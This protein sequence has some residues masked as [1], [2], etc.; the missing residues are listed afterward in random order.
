LLTRQKT[1]EKRSEIGE[2]QTK[3]QTIKDFITQ[4]SQTAKDE[5]H[6]RAKKVG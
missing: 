6:K 5:N 1:K 4:T 3:K 2:R